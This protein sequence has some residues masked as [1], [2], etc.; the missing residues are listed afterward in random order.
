MKTPEHLERKIRAGNS[1]A[2]YTSSVW[3]RTRARVFKRDNRECQRCKREGKVS[4]ATCVHHIKHLQAR[5]DLAL[6]TSNL[7]SL[8]D[9][10]HNLEHPE[11]LEAM[12]KDKD[13][14]FNKQIERW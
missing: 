3:R 8:C 14:F 7:I 11:K 10:C 6:D 12:Q 5:P 9:T 1:H 4:K 2:F 13:P